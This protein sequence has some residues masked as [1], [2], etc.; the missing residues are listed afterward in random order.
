MKYEGVCIA[1][2]DVNLSKN[3]I[4]IYLIWRYFKIMV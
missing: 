4:R 3:F 1:V 2:K